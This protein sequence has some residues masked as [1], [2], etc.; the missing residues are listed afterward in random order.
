MTTQNLTN[1]HTGTGFLAS[2][3]L[4]YQDEDDCARKLSSNLLEGVFRKLRSWAFGKLRTPNTDAAAMLHGRKILRGK[5]S[6]AFLGLRC[7][8]A[9]GRI[10][11]SPFG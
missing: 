7:Y 4:K 11:R 10:D 1:R 5:S 2:G 6:V 9:G 8:A 3:Q